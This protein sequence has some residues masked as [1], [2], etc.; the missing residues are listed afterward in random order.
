[1][2]KVNLV[3]DVLPHIIA[4]VAFLLLTMAYYSPTVLEGKRL[5]QHDVMQGL[6]GGGE[7]KA[8]REAT[9]E[10]ALWTN[11]MFGGMPAYLISVGWSGDVLKYVQY[12]FSLWLPGYSSVTMLCLVATYI[13]LL[14]F[15]VRPYLAMAGAI[16]YAFT[17]FNIIGIMAGHIWKVRAIA[18]MPLVLGGVHLLLKSKNKLLGFALTALAVGLEIRANHL[19]VTYYLFLLMLFYGVSIVVSSIQEK[20][21]P[22]LLKSAPWLVLAALLGLSSNMGR[23]W[24]TYEY[25]EYSTRGKSELTATQ[26]DSKAKSGLDKEYV[27]RWS[28]GKLE[29]MTL[30]IPNFYGGASADILVEDKDSQT[31][32]A[33]RRTNNQQ[34]AQQ[35][36]RYS[37]AYWG[38]QPGTAPYYAGAIVCFLC[39][40]G[41]VVL[42]KSVWVWL[43]SATVFSLM[44]SWGKNFEVFNDAMYHFFPGYNKFR[45]VTMSLVI[46]QL[47]MC[48]LAF[49]GLEKALQLKFSKA[50]QKK[51]LIALGA[52]GGLCL[53]LI[54]FAGMFDFQRSVESQLPKWFV[55]ALAEDRKALFRADAFRSFV[56]IALAFGV[57]YATLKEKMSKQV[58][59]MLMVAIILI[60]LWVIDKRFLND[61]L[62]VKNPSRTHF[63]L[64]EANQVIKSDKTLS[65]RVANV[66]N[67]WNEANTSY[68]HQS[69][70]GYHG[71]KIKRYQQLID[72]CLGG[73]VSGVVQ[74]LQKGQT[75]NAG[76]NMINM[77][78]TRYYMF[79]DKKNAVLQNSGAYG[80]AWMATTIKQVQNPDEEIEATCALTNKTTAVVDVNKFPLSQSNFSQGTITLKSYQP[81]ELVYE[82]NAQGEG[83]AIFSE[84][85]YP[86]GWTATIDGE[87]ADI[88]R[89]NY[90]L[91]ALKVPSG[92]HAIVFKFAPKAYAVGNKVMY[93]GSLATIVLMLLSLGLSLK[94]DSQNE[95]H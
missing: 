48:L 85:Y 34:Q 44:L 82:S 73:E 29:S 91:R 3:K 46:A 30:M 35:L 63:R 14:I 26:N 64:T 8:F 40:L 12:A 53:V 42:P 59:G 20:Q 6:G 18:Y 93:F 83:L 77:L 21:V 31:L 19:Q 79:G 7:V 67:P 17:S 43:V 39:V 9:G 94:K 45:A 95:P 47:A 75:D 62:F 74:N 33:L 61:S 36:A 58:A 23:L 70:G 55:N 92:K 90:V 65:F 76:F 37:S 69:I 38:E 22:N 68:H 52:T 25:G 4:I 54:L 89:A 84:I 28:S 87:P 15:G 51:L 10:E 86:K 88:L 78:N 60:D 32:K 56:F 1:M 5:A 71:A 50:L 81:N 66:L 16:A 13:M 24:S 41:I 11:A 80:N 57:V 49:L 27:F 72:Y 2:K